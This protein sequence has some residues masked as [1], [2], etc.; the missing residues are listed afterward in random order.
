[1]AGSPCATT[2][3]YDIASARSLA[4]RLLN[5]ILGY[6]G[7][8]I[9]AVRS[10]PTADPVEFKGLDSWVDEIIE[11]VR[12]FTMTSDERISALCHA[13]R[14]VVR[15]NVPGDIVECG[16]WRGGSMMAVASTLLGAGDASRMLYLFDTFDGMP[17]P[18]SIDRATQSGRPASELLKGADM[19]SDIRA[20]APLDEV[21]TNLASTGYPTERIRLIKG[22]VEDSIPTELPSTISILRLDT[23]WYESTR[24]EL[25]HLYPR[26]SLGGVLIID[27]Y[28]HWEG[29]RK[30]VDEYIDQ[31]RLQIL[32]QRIDYTGR[33]AVKTGAP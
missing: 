25:V 5:G 13:V 21:R 2:S 17:P 3:R 6:A 18:S 26:L 16:V 14:Y 19:S 20:Y 24:H 30:A 23:D 22:R 12:T 8:E 15:S 31:N 10:R 29:A 28:G 4:A 33:I 1:M 9:R 27:D 11:R 7:L 32:L